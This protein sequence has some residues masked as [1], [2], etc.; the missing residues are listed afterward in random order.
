MKDSENRR[1][2]QDAGSAKVARSGE[3]I[4]RKPH[5]VAFNIPSEAGIYVI[6]KVEDTEIK[7]L[8]DTGATVTLLAKKVF[9]EIKILTTDEPHQDIMTDEGK[10]L[11]LY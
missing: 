9:D 1:S 6:G 10:P 11:K 5:S 2:K 4:N 8:I 3:K 7:L